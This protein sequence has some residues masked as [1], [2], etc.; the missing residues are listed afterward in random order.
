MF[1]KVLLP[2]LHLF[3]LEYKTNI[4]QVKVGALVLVPFRRKMVTGV[5][6]EIDVTPKCPRIKEVAEYILP[7]TPVNTTNLR[8]LDLAAQYYLAELGDVAKMLLPV[9]LSKK[10]DIVQ[11]QQI[12]SHQCQLPNLSDEQ[13]SVFNVIRYS[14]S[15]TLL[16]GVTGSGKT[17]IYFHLIASIMQQDMQVLLL[18]PE[19]NLANHIAARFHTRFGF[20]SVIWHSNVS[21]AK[22]KQIL[23]G[24]LSNQIKVIIGTR[25]SLFLPYTSLGLIIIDEEHDQSYK[26]ESSI[27]YNA[28]DMAVL[29]GKIAQIPVLLS[30]ATPSLES[31]YNVKKQKYNFLELKSRFGNAILPEIHVVDLTKEYMSKGTWISPTLKQAILQTLDMKHQVLLFLNRKGYAP[32][33][34][35]SNCGFK[36]ICNSCSSRLV[37]HKSSNMLVCH[38]CSYSVMFQK[39]CL[40]CN[41]EKLV[42]CGPGIERIAEEVAKYF[43][44]ARVAVISR[45]TN[46]TGMLNSALIKSIVNNEVDII[47]GTQMLTKGYHF[48]NLHLVGIIDADLEYGGDLR[49][50]ERTYQLLNQI[51]GR[52]GRENTKGKVYI[53]TYY[54]DSLVL[55]Y[56]INFDDD[57]F[58]EHELD[59]RISNNMPPVTKFVAISVISASVQIAHDTAKNIVRTANKHNHHLRILGPAPAIIHKL[60]NKYRFVILL[61]FDRQFQIRDYIKQWNSLLNPPRTVQIKIDFDPYNIY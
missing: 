5:V 49:A 2:K 45:D 54:P 39:H 51:G 44:N 23:R 20:E 58:V 26:Q 7:D 18:M 15:T 21:K 17:E 46:S 25:S 52:A 59:I 13:Q 34:L 48:P 47:I 28:R 43:T 27:M 12:S 60:Q 57:S 14:Q 40:Q 24:I 9:E 30:S 3:P 10:P 56:L 61:I 55:N 22:K 8:F 29:R 6:W 53:Q 41:Q 36:F 19:I 37:Y 11:S 32:L 38:Y 42:A 50:N 1:I 35:C 16:K 31:I 4:Q 33:I